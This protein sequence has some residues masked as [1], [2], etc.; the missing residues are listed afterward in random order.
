MARILWSV[1]LYPPAHNCGSEY[2][3]HHVNKYLISRG[4]ECRVILHRYDGIP[5]VW[6]GVEVF[7]A[8]GRVDAF[9]WANCIMTH[10]DFTQ[11]TIIMANEARRPL[12]HFIHN[13]IEYSSIQ[14]ADYGQNIVYNS[15]WIKNK[16]GYRHPSFTLHPPCDIEYYN[17]NE[18]PEHNEYITLV[19]L[20]ERKGGYMLIKI[21]EALPDRKFLGIVG[22]YDN[23]GPM[24]LNQEQIIAMMPPNVTVV[25][26]SPD[27]LSV[28]K[29]TRALLMP[30]DYES[31]G[32]TATEAM[33]NGIPVICTPTDGLRENCGE[34]GIYV[35][36]PRIDNEPGAA[37]VYLGT[38]Q[39]WVSAIRS[40]DDK[41]F[42][43]KKSVDCRAR[44]GELD[45]LKELQGLEEFIMNARY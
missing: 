16:I 30:S 29:K 7:P 40:L 35:G 13:D 38:V 41:T 24:K 21:A 20:N 1:H 43:Q 22:S 36:S 26:N 42:Y 33:C 27:I 34:A 4:H 15:H 28:Y 19:S 2:V 9:S 14:N 6:E 10:L 32:R 39:D 18:N 31:W 5:Y 12:F 17:V 3:A 23:P 45:P 25:P 11:F 37:S 44:A 8:T